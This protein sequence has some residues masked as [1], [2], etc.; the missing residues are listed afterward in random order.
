[1]I[2]VVSGRMIFINVMK[3]IA[4][5]FHKRRVKTMRNNNIIFFV[6]ILVSMFYSL[7]SANEYPEYTRTDYSLNAR[8]K[9][10]HI[11]S[12][13]QNSNKD[14]I[15]VDWNGA[16]NVFP[17]ISNGVL[18]NKVITE[19]GIY[20]PKTSTAADFNNDGLTDVCVNDTLFV[21]IGEGKFA[22]PKSL[23]MEGLQTIVSGDMNND[24][25]KDL[26][27]IVIK[28]AAP[29]MRVAELRT[30]FGK[31]DGTFQE[32]V[33][34]E[35]IFTSGE[36]N[37]EPEKGNQIDDIGVYEILYI[38]DLTKDTIPDLLVYHY[39]QN[40]GAGFRFNR[41]YT[42]NNDGTFIKNSL[43]ASGD[44]EVL[45]V[46]DFNG[47]GDV[48]IMSSG[49]DNSSSDYNKA[50][51]Y[52]GNGKGDFV[53]SGEIDPNSTEMGLGSPSRIFSLTDTNNDGI[54]DLIIIHQLEN[55]DEL[56]MVAWENEVIY[57]KIHKFSLN[58]PKISWGY[59]A[60]FYPDLLGLIRCNFNNDNY[61][62][63]IIRIS[64]F[65][66]NGPQYFSVLLSKT[67]SI[68]NDHKEN[69]AF[70]IGQNTPNPFNSST[71]IPYEIG[72]QG[73]YEH[74]VYDILGRKIKTL[75]NGLK[76]KGSFQTT[77]DGR[78]DNGKEMATGIYFSA[79]KKAGGKE[80]LQTRKLL[81][82][83]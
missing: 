54:L 19:T 79:L 50:P 67:L 42:G 58:L 10:I 74:A 48:D 11:G 5:K 29:T 31:G 77:W 35:I 15:I 57:S 14:V 12:E 70:F 56:V 33:K 32:P 25:N 8:V 22:A 60:P 18:G 45:G 1:M 24:G 65:P 3:F 62:D 76:T 34:T 38:G 55:S 7:S 72:I 6:F 27:A 75:F 41:S 71:V 21:A 26:I 46:Y 17:H 59:H 69:K 2:I 4:S 64:S 23:G 52:T 78:D 61:S 44:A 39:Y 83:K 20:N 66:Y 82:I 43:Y 47:D 73:Y 28:Y 9:F 68:V 63:F 80:G 37:W 13:N 49:Y 51:I 53:F 30:Y 16:I 36:V 40:W 81:L